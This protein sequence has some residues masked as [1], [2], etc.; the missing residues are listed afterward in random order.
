MVKTHQDVNWLDIVILMAVCALISAV[1]S[2]CGATTGWKVEFGVSPITS[3]HDEKG[4][5]TRE[6]KHGNGSFETLAH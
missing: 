3:V 2:G 5:N 1:L 6:L 4:L